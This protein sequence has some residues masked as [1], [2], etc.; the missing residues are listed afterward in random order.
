MPAMG[1][2]R[3]RGWRLHAGPGAGGSF[4]GGTLGL[5][6]SARN[7]RARLYPPAGPQP[8]AGLEVNV[9]PATSWTDTRRALLVQTGSV[10]LPAVEGIEWLDGGLGRPPHF[11]RWAAEP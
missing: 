10:R 3:C 1:C 4:G 9:E 7:V 2:W 11:L 8:R 6:G 5:R